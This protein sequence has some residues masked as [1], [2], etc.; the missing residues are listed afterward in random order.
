MHPLKLAGLSAL[1]FALGLANV[2]AQADVVVVVSAKSTVTKL[3]QIQVAEIFLGKTARFPSGIHAVPID[4][5]E[6]TS[7]R[8]EFY[9][10]FASKSAAQLKAHWSKII[11]TGRG[12]PP[13][14]A[15]SGAETR[16]RV[17]ADPNAIGYLERDT[18]DSSVR[19]VL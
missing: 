16:K 10:K 2:S 18:A 11:F 15:A 12:Q 4:Q 19:I 1:G 7:V 17:A 5:G 14:A 6:G 8:D 3:S 13:K 9:A